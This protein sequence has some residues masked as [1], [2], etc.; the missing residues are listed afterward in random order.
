MKGPGFK[1]RL[2]RLQSLH[3]FYVTKGL[4]FAQLRGG[5]NAVVYEV[6]R[7]PLRYCSHEVALEMLWFPPY[8]LHPWLLFPVCESHLLS[9]LRDMLPEGRHL[10]LPLG[11]PTASGTFRI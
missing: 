7:E 4:A 10:L 5:H 1:L 6:P 3:T 9:L 2:T 8:L 11:L